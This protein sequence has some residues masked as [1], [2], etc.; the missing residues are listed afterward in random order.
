MLLSCEEEISFGLI[1]E[2]I[3]SDYPDGDSRQAWKNLL[4]KFESATMATKTKLN[5]EFITKILEDATEDPDKWITNVE[6]LRQRLKEMNHTISD[7]DL[8]IHILNNVPEEY[9]NLVEMLEDQLGNTTNPL[10]WEHLRE[11]L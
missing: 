6:R 8:M 2:A 7:E 1:D 4:T 9:D 10:T 3:T 5:K 11:R